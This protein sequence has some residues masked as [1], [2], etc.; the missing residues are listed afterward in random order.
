MEKKE[1]K[2]NMAADKKDI[3]I[4]HNLKETLKPYLPVVKDEQII[5]IE[6]KEELIKDIDIPE[7]I[8]PMICWAVEENEDKEIK[9]IPMNKDYILI[10]GESELLFFISCLLDYFQ[11]G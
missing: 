2:V 7:E 8:K 10:H 1:N 4:I 6:D 5:E 3:E 9:I 11:T